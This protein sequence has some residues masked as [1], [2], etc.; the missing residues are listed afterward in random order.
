[1]S[2]LWIHKMKYQ[3]QISDPQLAVW[4]RETHLSELNK[5]YI[6]EMLTKLDLVLEY[7]FLA[8]VFVDITQFLIRFVGSA[9]IRE[10]I[11]N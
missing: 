1:M 11:G 8:R 7:L 10:I 4:A 3:G 6:A 2:I 5:D 9:M